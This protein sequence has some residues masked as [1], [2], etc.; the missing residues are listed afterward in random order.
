VRVRWQEKP[1]ITHVKRIDKNRYIDLKTGEEREY[2][3]MDEEKQKLARRAALNRTFQELDMIIRANFNAHE[4]P[5]RQRFITLTYAENMTDEKRLFK[6]FKNFVDRLEYAF[7]KKAP[8]TYVNVAEPQGRGAWHHHLMIK[9]SDPGVKSLYIDK[10]RLTEIWRH[11]YTSVKQLNSDDV[12]SYYNAYFKG[13]IPEAMGRITGEEI[14]KREEELGKLMDKITGDKEIS[15]LRLKGERL[16][17][18]PKGFRLYRC[19][20]SVFR[21]QKGEATFLELEHDD[22]YERRFEAGYELKTLEENGV[23]TKTL[24]RGY[25]ADYKKEVQ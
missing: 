12:G 20:R 22:D 7:P 11:G 24:N 13:I 9:P 23:D 16:R 8:F 2:E 1:T 6:D 10:E 17:F 21:P 15:K 19:S 25:R 18:Y 4:S 3:R 5:H 14:F